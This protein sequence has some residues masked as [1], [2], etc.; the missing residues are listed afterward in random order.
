M[1]PHKFNLPEYKR[2]MMMHVNYM[3]LIDSANPNHF[4]HSVKN[5]SVDHI[6]VFVDSRK[7]AVH[8]ITFVQ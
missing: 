7:K 1:D 4:A 2:F 8:V 5:T 3:I 6:A